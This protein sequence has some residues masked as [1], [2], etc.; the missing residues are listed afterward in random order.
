MTTALTDAI[1]GLLDT[2]AIRDCIH[3]YCRGINRL[4]AELLT[5]A[6]HAS[7]EICTG[8]RTYSVPAFIEQY[9]NRQADT[10]ACQHYVT[11]TMCEIDGDMAHAETYFWSVIRRFDTVDV[12][13]GRYVD[14]LDNRDRAWRISQRV[15]VREWNLS[16]LPPDDLARLSTGAGR[17]DRSD[18]SY[19]RPLRSRSDC[20]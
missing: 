9:W 20:V 2:S 17:R 6:F 7:A 15:V 19:E 12:V 11:N 13:G 8:D 4:D 1:R 10:Q 5:S 18:P 16:G 14:R 3:R